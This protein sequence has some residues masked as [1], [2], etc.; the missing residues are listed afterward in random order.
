MQNATVQGTPGAAQLTLVSKSLTHSKWLSGQEP[1]KSIM[2]GKSAEW[3]TTSARFWIGTK[4]SATYSFGNNGK[5]V[6]NWDI[7][8]AGIGTFSCYSSL[9]AFPITYSV[10]PSN[11]YETTVTFTFSTVLK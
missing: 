1:P 3:I 7:P 4:G 5:V 10:G 11:N 9:G 6:V 8:Y 2:P